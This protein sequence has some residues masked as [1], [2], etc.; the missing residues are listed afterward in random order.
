MIPWLI[1][2]GWLGGV[3]V[4]SR[5]VANWMGLVRSWRY[6]DTEFKVMG[7]VLCFLMC[8]MTWPGVLVFV[9]LRALFGL[10]PLPHSGRWVRW[11]YTLDREDRKAVF[12]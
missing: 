4:A 6:D 11:F 1:V 9:A 12:R 3:V 10:I 5:W 2:F 8:L 7:S